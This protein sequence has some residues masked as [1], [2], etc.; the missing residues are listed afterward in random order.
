M[1]IFD[2]S[3]LGITDKEVSIETSE[4]HLSAAT[5]MTEQCRKHIC[6]ISR[7]LDPLVYDVE[8]FV[9]TVKKMLLANRR[10]KVRILVFESQA[11]SRRGHQLLNLAGK[12]PSYIEFRRPGKEYDN[13]NESLFIADGTGYVYRNSATR[14][15]GSINFND[16]RKSKTFMDVFEE[17]WSRSTP[18]ANLRQITI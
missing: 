18:D 7:E 1:T 12:L 8:S 17:M 10:A 9:E 3:Q 15:E 4:G 16:N 6:I 2:N 11:I 13:F 14:F 5:L